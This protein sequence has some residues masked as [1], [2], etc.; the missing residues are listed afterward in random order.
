MPGTL[1]GTLKNQTSVSWYIT[2]V[3]GIFW[4]DNFTITC[5]VFLEKIG[6]DPLESPAN[7]DR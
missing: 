7:T 4:F 5:T 3:F 6:S 1:K 2:C